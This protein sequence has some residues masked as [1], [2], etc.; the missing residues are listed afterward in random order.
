[1]QMNIGQAAEAVG[2]PKKTIRY[3]ESIDLIPSAKRGANGY[4]FYGGGD[5]ERLSFI[6]R[7]R[8]LGFSL[9]EC[10]VLLSLN[11]IETR[12]SEEIRD[13]A[14]ANE[15]KIEAKIVELKAMKKGIR[16]LIDQCAGGQSP[17]CKILEALS[18][19]S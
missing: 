10:R 17:D 8:A 14:I 16:T 15:R 13:T 12:T 2:L 6:S 19:P 3:Y 4:R 11:E 1:M 9:E 5:I 18:K 7:A